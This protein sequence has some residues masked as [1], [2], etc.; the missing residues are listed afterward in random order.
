[1]LMPQLGETV[2]EGKI[3]AWFKSV[4]DRVNA[5][6]NLFEIETDKTAME[7]P[8]TSAGV[9]A[10]IRVAAGETVPVGTVV[11]VISDGDGAVVTKPPAAPKLASAP[12]ETTA[13]PRAAVAPSFSP[14][15]P[16]PVTP[17]APAARAFDPF[18]EVRLPDRG[19]GPAHLPSGIPIT[20]LARRLAVEAGL[21]L[22]T[23]KGSGPHGRVVAHDITADIKGRR[24][25]A[26]LYSIQAKPATS[27]PAEFDLVPHD[28]VRR[29]QALALAAAKHTVPQ[30]VV[31]REV[32]LDT[33]LKLIEEIN[34][35]DPGFGVSLVHCVAKAL[36]F[37]LAKVP[38]ANVQWADDHMLRFRQVDLAVADADGA[39]IAIRAADRN[40]LAVLA[41]ELRDGSR[42][43][44][45]GVSAVWDMSASSIGAMIAN[46]RPPNTTAL[47]I[48]AVARRPVVD[49][50]RIVV[51]SRATLSL[52]CDHRAI[53]GALGA[54]LLGAC[55]AALEK[56]LTLIL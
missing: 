2:A 43:G 9:V 21:D 35:V 44:I 6:D 11:A 26:P 56:P 27:G 5:G 18:N 39:P 19:Y 20:P 55:V 38:E 1:V 3:S 41:A 51:A 25:S 53:D 22:T 40:G 49:G 7:V 12:P 42:D 37:A 14:A 28:A 8:T 32:T 30:F 23:L 13:A 52:T 34:A 33:V 36:A 29:Q 50:E 45:T 16:A 15:V 24:T 10:E 31:H 54:R 46:V 17:A 47:T 48:G 4:G